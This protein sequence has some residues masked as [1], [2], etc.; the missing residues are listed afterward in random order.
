MAGFDDPAAGAPVG[1]A[2][3]ELD[4][5]A[6]AADVRGESV[7]ADELARVDVVVGPV[8]ADPLRLRRGRL[9]ALDRDRAKRRLQQLVI[10]AVGARVLEPDRDSRAFAEDRSLRPFLARSV[11]FGPVFGP[12]SGAFVSAP[13]QASQAQSIPTTAS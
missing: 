2:G 3:L 9:G 11:G 7:L 4:L 10:V 6:A 5:L 8:K 13:S 1:A 12:P